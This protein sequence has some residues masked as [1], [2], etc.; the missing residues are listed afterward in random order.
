MGIFHAF[1]LPSATKENKRK[2]KEV[3]LEE[4]IKRTKLFAL[5][6]IVFEALLIV[7]HLPKGINLYVGLYVVLFSIAAIYLFSLYMMRKKQVSIRYRMLLVHMIVFLFLTWGTMITLFDQLHYGHVMAF[8]VNYMCVSTLFL[9]N[10]KHYLL[11]AIPNV[12][13]L[14]VGLPFFQTSADM[15]S[16]HYTNLTVF[17]FFCWLASQLLYKGFAVNFYNKLLLTEMNE[18]LEAQIA[19]NEG[20][21]EQLKKQAMQDELTG[22]PNRRGFQ[23]YIRAALIDDAER[24]LS[25]FLLDVD[26]FK[27]YNDHYGHLRG[28]EVL[29][30]IAQSVYQDTAIPSDGWARYGGEEFVL[31]VFDRSADELVQLAEAIRQAVKKLHMEH[32]YSPAADKVTVSMGIY[33]AVISSWEQLPDFLGQAD[34]ALYEAKRSGRNTVVQRKEPSESFA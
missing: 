14:Y 17:I 19:Q 20:M 7:M 13:F 4:N 18:A 9:A 6:V 31:A 15:L 5:I 22:V 8:V 2:L 30:L 21:N 1:T 23:S 12:L 26:A 28:D 16:G 27:S 10:G 29:R 33:S 25:V 24:K 11:F 34:E 32:A 3:V